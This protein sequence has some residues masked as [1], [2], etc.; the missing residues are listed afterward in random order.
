MSFSLAPQV[1]LDLRV[2]SFS[3]P[4]CNISEIRK[5]LIAKKVFC[6]SLRL[7]LPKIR[8]CFSRCHWIAYTLQ[9][10]MAITQIHTHRR[11][12]S[13]SW[14][15]GEGGALDAS[16][17]HSGHRCVQP[18]RRREEELRKHPRARLLIQHGSPE[19]DSPA[20]ASASR[21]LQRLRL[22]LRQKTALA[23]GLAV[24]QH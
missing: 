18:C 17:P 9:H 15:N 19:V 11:N 23:P 14:R 22:S 21:G 10:A 12:R 20:N 13:G 4:L 16:Q 3:G 8:S 2:S 24:A 6:W 5:F 7:R 1:C